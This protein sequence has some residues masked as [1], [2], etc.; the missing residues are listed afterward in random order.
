MRLCGLLV[1]EKAGLNRT[2][3]GKERVTS[4]LIMV[5]CMVYKIIEHAKSDK[6]LLVKLP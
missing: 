1:V 5:A 6:S 3:K 4:V 2:K